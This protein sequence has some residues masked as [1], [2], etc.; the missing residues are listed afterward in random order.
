M[1]SLVKLIAKLRHE[2]AVLRDQVARLKGELHGNEYDD[3][4]ALQAEDECDTPYYIC[5]VCQMTQRYD[6]YCPCNW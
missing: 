2:N 5:G 4:L 3:M 6:E 1:R